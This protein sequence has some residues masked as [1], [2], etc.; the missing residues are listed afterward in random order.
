MKVRKAKP[1]MGRPR[2]FD[3][4]KALERAMYVFWKKGYLGASLSDLTKAMKI[5]RPS[6]Y[7]AFGDKEMLFR[8]ALER[9]FSGPACYLRQAVD[10]PTAREVAE[11]ILRGSVLRSTDPSNPPGCLWVHGVLSCGGTS[12]PLYQEVAARRAKG[13]ELLQERFERARKQGD[14]PPD[15]EPGTLARFV[16]TSVE[17]IAVQ[18]QTGSSRAELLKMVDYLLRCWPAGVS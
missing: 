1:Q 18:A 3:A 13:Q 15:A 5:S 4:E 16:L 8:K 2:E 9:Y 6:L 11:Q 12:D 7:A 14:L 10:A 17:G